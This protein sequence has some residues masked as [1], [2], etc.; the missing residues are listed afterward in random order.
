MTIERAIEIVKRRYELL[1]SYLDARTGKM[2]IVIKAESELREILGV[3]SPEGGL[4]LFYSDV[5]ELARGD[6]TIRELVERKN[7]AVELGRRGGNVI[8]QRGSA[9][10]KQLQAKRKNPSGGRPPKSK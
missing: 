8:A 4:S 2:M 5:K 3:K 9:Y 1:A 7:P 10:F 6:V